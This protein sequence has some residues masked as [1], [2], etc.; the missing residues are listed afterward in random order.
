M[1]GAI[2]GDVCGSV[3]EFD[4]CKTD[5]VNEIVLL[6]KN[7]S[8]TD[9]SVLAVAVADACLGNGDY[10]AAL[11]KWGRACDTVGYGRAFARWL[12]AENPQPYNSWGNGSAMRVA[13]VA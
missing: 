13:P 10:Q 3:Y 4:N 2:I 1:L 8:Y 7:C 12:T 5:R 9:D 11:L 6:Q